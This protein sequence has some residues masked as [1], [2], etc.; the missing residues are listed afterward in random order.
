[1]PAL[2]RCEPI[3]CDTYLCRHH[4]LEFV[5]GYL[6]EG[7]QFPHQHPHIIFVD[8]HEAEIERSPANANIRIPQAFQDRVA[9]PLHRIW[10]N[11]NN[12]IQGI[13]RNITDIIVLVSQEFSENVDAQHP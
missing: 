7:Q 1:M 9:M 2:V 10:F 6:Q 13:Q 11:C 4:G 12:L 3:G 5:V 8:Q